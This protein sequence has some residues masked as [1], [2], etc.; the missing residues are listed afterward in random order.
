MR[1]AQSREA[2]QHTAGWR[3]PYAREQRKL[4]VLIDAQMVL[5]VQGAKTVP[6]G[7]KRRRR[8]KQSGDDYRTNDAA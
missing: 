4:Q 3:G 5:R 6:T 8:S 2:D 1:A 7:H